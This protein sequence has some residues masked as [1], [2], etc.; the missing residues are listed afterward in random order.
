MDEYREKRGG[1]QWRKLGRRADWRKEPGGEQQGRSDETPGGVVEARGQDPTGGA[2]RRSGPGTHDKGHGPAG[3]EN[4]LAARE[5]GKESGEVHEPGAGEASGEA[6][7]REVR[8]K[9]TA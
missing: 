9:T 2:G 7:S 3:G 8:G 1:R 4:R 6:G 5:A